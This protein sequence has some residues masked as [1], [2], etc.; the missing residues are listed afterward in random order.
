[1]KNAIVNYRTYDNELLV[2]HHKKVSELS[3]ELRF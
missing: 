2:Y 1:M 3:Q